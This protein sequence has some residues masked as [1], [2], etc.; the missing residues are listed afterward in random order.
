MKKLLLVMLVP[1]LVLGVMSCK[2][3]VPD[4]DGNPLSL[5][6]YYKT[7][8]GNYKPDLV[9]A[10]NQITLLKDEGNISFRTSYDGPKGTNDSGILAVG[11]EFKITFN[12]FE[13]PYGEVGTI[14]AK[15][16]VLTPMTFKIDTLANEGVKYESYVQNVMLP[17]P[18]AVYVKE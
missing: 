12:S 10:G 14:K 6:G 2:A 15:V 5:Q 8:S 16:T 17:Q 1:V 4:G 9:I 7:S 13:D 11:D 3:K 18:E